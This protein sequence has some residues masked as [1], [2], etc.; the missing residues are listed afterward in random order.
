MIFLKKITDLNHF[1]WKN[2]LYDKMSY[3]GELNGE[4]STATKGIQC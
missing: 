2:V 3:W 4:K 1:C